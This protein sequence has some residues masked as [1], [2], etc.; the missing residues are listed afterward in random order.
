MDKLRALGCCHIYSARDYTLEGEGGGGD[1]EGGAAVPAGKKGAGLEG[2]HCPPSLAFITRWVG[3]RVYA[4][5]HAEGT[6]ARCWRLP[7]AHVA[8]GMQG[9][10]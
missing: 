8:A 2:L 1:G 7:Q 3:V 5:V 9:G 6:V 10:G 4:Q